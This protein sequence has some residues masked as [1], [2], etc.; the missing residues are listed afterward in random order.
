VRLTGPVSSWATRAL[1]VDFGSDTDDENLQKERRE[2]SRPAVV[3]P[4]L[5]LLWRYL[6]ELTEM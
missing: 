4:L 1:G 6:M 3:A 2:L 5:V